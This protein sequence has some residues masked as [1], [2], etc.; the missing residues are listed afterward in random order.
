MLLNNSVGSEG[1]KPWSNLLKCVLYTTE[2]GYSLIYIYP[3]W[4]AHSL[5]V[6]RVDE[7]HVQFALC[8]SSRSDFTSLA[9]S[10]V[11]SAAELSN[12]VHRGISTLF[13]L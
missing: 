13:Y 2:S 7:N 8:K 5:L 11:K 1:P 9:A 10:K 4:K 3:V 6:F 12:Y